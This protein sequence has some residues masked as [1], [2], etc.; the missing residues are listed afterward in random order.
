MFFGHKC[1]KVTPVWLPALQ[2]KISDAFLIG[3]KGQRDCLK[4]PSK[5]G[6]IKDRKGLTDNLWVIRLEL[7]V[8][9]ISYGKLLFC[10]QPNVGECHALLCI[11]L[12]NRQR[13]R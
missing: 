11:G 1:E 2:E 9:T 8:S 13:P 4:F 12:F 7:D 3:L 10:K 6:F 5:H